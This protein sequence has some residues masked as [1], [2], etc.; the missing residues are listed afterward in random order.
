MR[1]ALDHA[2]NVDEA[3]AIFRKTGIDFTGDPPLHYLVAD[4]SGASAVIEY[5]DGKVHVLRGGRV[6][7]N[8]VLTGST[9]A[10]R[11]HDRRYHTATTALAAAGGLL[12][13]SQTLGLLKRVRQRI[14]RWSVAYDM[15]HRTLEVVMG[16]RYGRVLRFSV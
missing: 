8:F 4:P 9:P 1:L 3:I 2:A 10:E 6:I 13:S 12:S 11:A 16:Q 14:T 7:T 15:R 5:I